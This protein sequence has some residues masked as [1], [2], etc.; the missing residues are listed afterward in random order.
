MKKETQLNIAS[1]VAL[2][3]GA[4]FVLAFAAWSFKLFLF[5]PHPG[6]GS[7]ILL[8]WGALAFISLFFYTR[9]RRAMKNLSAEQKE[10]VSR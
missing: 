7:W 10:T 9:T 2:M 4:Y 8:I 6:K 1:W 3:L 5:N